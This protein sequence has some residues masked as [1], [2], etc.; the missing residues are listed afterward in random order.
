MKLADLDPDAVAAAAVR[1]AIDHLH[2]VALGLEPAVELR[3]VAGDG[4]TTVPDDEVLARGTDLGLTTRAL[5]VYAQRGLP[6]WDW[7]HSGMAADGLLS[8]LSALYGRAADPDLSHTAIDVVDDVDPSDEVGLVLVAAAARIR[9]GQSAPVTARE[10][11]ALAGMGAAGVRVYTRSGE[12]PT[13]NER[14]AR[15]PA[16]DAARWLAARGIEGLG[17]EGS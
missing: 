11:G 6:V 5:T 4:S 7:T 12:L 2:R 8:V 13:T 15:V 9:I 14:P 1:A 16:D 10:L 17:R 3:L